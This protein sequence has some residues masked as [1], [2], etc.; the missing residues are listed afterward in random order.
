MDANV[1]VVNPDN[2]AVILSSA[3]ATNNNN[4]NSSIVTKIDDND[5][6]ND[7]GDDA[8]GG[9]DKRLLEAASSGQT[10]LVLQLLEEEGQRLHSF[11]DKVRIILP[12]QYS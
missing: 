6:H 4:V 7:Q 5:I 10:D 8:L 2:P 3:E 9:L 12:N 1:V 11:K